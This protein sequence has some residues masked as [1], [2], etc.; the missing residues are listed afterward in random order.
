MVHTHSPNKPKKFKQTSARKLMAAVFW[1]RKQVLMLEFMQ[2][3]TA[4]TLEMHCQTPKELRRAIENKR[5]G[6]LISDVLVVL[7]RDNVCPHTAA[8]T[9][10]LLEHF[11]WELFDHPPYSPGLR[12]T[13]TCL[14]TWRTGCDHS[15]SAIMRSLWKVLKRG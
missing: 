15:A 5:R 6:M 9:R 7:H 4:V 1:D 8:R 3:G 11:S 14:L 12:A 10:A 13:T 2:Q